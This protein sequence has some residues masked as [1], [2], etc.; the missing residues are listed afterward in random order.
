MIDAFA[1]SRRCRD[2]A[3]ELRPSNC[4]SAARCARDSPQQLT[5]QKIGSNRHLAVGWQ[6]GNVSHTNFGTRRYFGLPLQ[7]KATNRAER[8]RAEPETRDQRLE[9]RGWRP[10]TRNKRPEQYRQCWNQSQNQAG[11]GDSAKPEPEPE[12]S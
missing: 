1:L 5:R 3:E 2:P 8:E 9:T 12:P 10:K 11:A 4:P 7:S 6:T